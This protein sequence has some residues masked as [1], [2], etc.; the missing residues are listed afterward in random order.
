MSTRW[1]QRVGG[2]RP[3]LDRERPLDQRRQ[4]VVTE[5]VE[6]EHR[7]PADERG[8]DLEERVLRGRP[9]EGE[10]ALLDRGQQ[11]V[12]LRLVEPMDLIE[13]EDGAPP[14]LRHPG[15]GPVDD[16]PHVAHPRRHRRQGDE[17]TVGLRRHHPGQRRLA[18]ARRT[19]EDDRRQ[20]VGLDERPQRRARPDQVRLADDLVEGAGSHPRR[21]R[22]LL[23]EPLAQRGFDRV[24][25]RRPGT[26]PACRHPQEATRRQGPRHF[27]QGVED[28]VLAPGANR[29]RTGR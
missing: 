3:A 13:E 19:P 8:V 23:G 29:G 15:A 24:V 22:R 21:Q 20:A 9:D 5:R 14:L 16:L 4:V 17:L 27:D 18:R 28:D 26:G 12:L 2:D 10:H 11:G 25:G 6:P 7:R 1:A